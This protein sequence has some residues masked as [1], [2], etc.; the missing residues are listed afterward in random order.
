VKK[1][2][3]ITGAGHFPGMGSAIAEY[4]INQG[5]YVAINS[6][7]IDDRWYDIQKE[8]PNT[9]TI[10]KGDITDQAI[11]NRLLSETLAAWGQVDVLINNASTV[12]TSSSPDREEWNLE[13]LMNVVVPYELSM[14]FSPYLK[15][16]NGSIVMIGSRAGI[17]VAAS[18]DNPHNL[19]YSIAK[20]AQ[21]HLTKSLAVILSPEVTVNSIAPGYFAS[22]RHKVKFTDEMIQF[23]K[24]RFERTSLT[25]EVLNENGIIDS[26]LF[27][28]NT[29]NVTGQIL[30]VC[31]G[32]SVHRI[33]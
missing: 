1:V 11:Q 28:A 12:T 33:V 5:C 17:Q 2:F 31:A 16:V 19:S 27:L 4:L 24:E 25:N 30:P 8:F 13:F 23:Q 22:S 9:L 6:R 10:V 15:A 14:K 20:S 18:R 29:R 26:V 32:A 21:Q 7:N 3:V